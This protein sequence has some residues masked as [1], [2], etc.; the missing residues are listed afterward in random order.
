[1]SEFIGRDLHVGEFLRCQSNGDYDTIQCI[2]EDCICVDALDAAPT[3]PTA[4]P[5]NITDISNETM[6]CCKYS[7]KFSRNLSLLNV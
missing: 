6:R 3:Y 1:M 4:S 5:V 7:R 2:G